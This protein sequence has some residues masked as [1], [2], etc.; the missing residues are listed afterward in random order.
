[1]ERAAT[2]LEAPRA[3]LAQA[4]PAGRPLLLEKPAQ[5]GAEDAAAHPAKASQPSGLLDVTG[6][7]VVGDLQGG[8]TDQLPDDYVSGDGSTFYFE[9]V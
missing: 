4:Q 1:M 2:E 3:P 7:L 8:S 5:L 9:E 6:R